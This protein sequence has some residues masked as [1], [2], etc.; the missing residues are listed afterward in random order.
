MA[1][2]L[3]ATGCATQDDA[4]ATVPMTPDASSPSATPTPTDSDSP[5]PVEPDAEPTVTFDQMISD[6]IIDKL[7]AQSPG[8]TGF[9]HTQTELDTDYSLPTHEAR[10]P[11]KPRFGDETIQPPH[12]SMPSKDATVRDAAQFVDAYLATMDYTITTGDVQPLATVSNT[13]C[14]H[15]TEV[16]N[17]V[18]GARGMHENKQEIAMTFTAFFPNGPLRLV[19]SDGKTFHFRASAAEESYVTENLGKNWFTQTGSHGPLVNDIVVFAGDKG[20]RF[21]WY[22]PVTFK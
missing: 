9:T 6:P 4:R 5:Q 16:M 3:S 10:S 17:Y 11:F 1:L 21:L 20:W 18:H 8:H 14:M 15:C 2:A 22:Q 19:K 12:I 7:F 13:N